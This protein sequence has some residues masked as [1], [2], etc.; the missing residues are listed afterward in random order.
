MN[1][2]VYYL[3]VCISQLKNNIVN[4]SYI[5]VLSILR[6]VVN[7]PLEIKINFILNTWDDNVDLVMVDL[8]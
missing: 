3:N 6:Y 4:T 7:E 8:K 2:C 1:V 5:C